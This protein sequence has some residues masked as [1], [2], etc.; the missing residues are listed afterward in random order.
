MIPFILISKKYNDNSTYKF[1]YVKDNINFTIVILVGVLVVIVRS[2]M[3]YGIPLSWNKTIMQTVILFCVM[4]IG[5]ALGGILSDLIGIRKTA[6][7]STIFAIPFLCFGNNYMFISL[8]GVMLFSMTMP[9]TLAILVSKLKNTPGLAFGLTTVG[10]FLGTLPI[11]FIKVNTITNII[12]IICAS[13]LCASL[14]L[15]VLKENRK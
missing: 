1:N 2:Y 14:L 7:I 9:I 12:I 8:I 6:I 3:G 10:L 4:G 15:Y 11:F 5:K 13:I